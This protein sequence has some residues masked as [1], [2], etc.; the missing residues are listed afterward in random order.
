MEV[1]QKLIWQL[2]V[3]EPLNKDA[4][5]LVRWSR[6]SFFAGCP[7]SEPMMIDG[8]EYFLFQKCNEEWTV[9]YAL[10]TALDNYGRVRL[11]KEGT[12]VSLEPFLKDVIKK[13]GKILGD[14]DSM[15]RTG[16]MC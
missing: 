4:D 16:G 6:T 12:E 15:S 5:V 8:I 1:D 7:T 11:F 14:Y 3:A 10:T 13:G 2:W 9:K